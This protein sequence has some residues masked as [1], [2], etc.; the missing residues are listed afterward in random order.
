RNLETQTLMSNSIFLSPESVNLKPTIF[1]MLTN[2]TDHPDFTIKSQLFNALQAKGYTVVTHP[3][4]AS[5]ILQINILQ[6]G[7][8]SK[9]AAQEM[10]SEGYGGTLEG[11]VSGVAIAS[12][13]GANVVAGGIAGGVA[14]SVTDNFVKNVTYTVISDIK[15]SQKFTNK[16]IVDKTRILSTAN[17]V[18]LEFDHAKPILTTGLSDAISGLFID[19]KES[20]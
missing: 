12:T 10:M 2:T 3:Q 20:P 13:A 5:F 17:Q 11:I 15:L 6:V 7:Q 18:N 9:T 19:H 8:K 1:V 16:T 4:N 14:T